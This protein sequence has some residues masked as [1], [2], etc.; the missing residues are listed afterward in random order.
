M[1]APRWK[2]FEKLVEEIQKDL[3]GDAVVTH[4]DR[5]MGTRSGVP[6][7]IDVSIR[8]RVGQFDLLIVMDC[9]DH[10]RA[11]DVKDVEDFI[12]L[13]QDVGANKAAMAAVIGYSEAAKRRA[14]DAGIELYRPLDTGDHD[15]KS[16]VEIPIVMEFI[17]P[18]KFSLSFAGVDGRAFSPPDDADIRKLLLYDKDQRLLGTVRDLIGQKWNVQQIPQEPGEHRGIELAPGPL[19]FQ[20]GR[21]FQQ[22][23]IVAQVV[24]ES[25]LHF[26]HWPISKVSGFL[27]ES[28]GA[29]VTRRVEFGN[30]SMIDAEQT[31]PRIKSLDDLAVRPAMVLRVLDHPGPDDEL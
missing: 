19:K 18:T 15:W 24:V 12:G 13:S 25:R 2:R 20:A 5:I 4:N 21:A 23:Y 8:S 10:N 9:K 28:S 17:G 7:Q 30:L 29:I 11:L 1:E 26:G 22:A 31:W 6:R 27:D 14:R 16:V 3:A